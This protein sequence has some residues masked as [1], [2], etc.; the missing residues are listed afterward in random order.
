M[1]FAVAYGDRAMIERYLPTNY[2][3][4][5]QVT[6]DLPH[7]DAAMRAP[8]WLIA[9]TDDHGWTMDGYV[10]PRLRSGLVPVQR[11]SLTQKDAP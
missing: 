1:H 3:V 9:G 8:G 4:F 2:R 10:I 11:L 6:P 7:F 5:G